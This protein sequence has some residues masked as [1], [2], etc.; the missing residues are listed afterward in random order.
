V[1]M[2]VSRS[3]GVLGPVSKRQLLI[4]FLDLCNHEATSVHVL[5]GRATPGEGLWMT[6]LLVRSAAD[7]VV[8]SWVQVGSCGSWQGRTSRRG[9]R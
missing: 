4:P 5:T 3:L 9:T 7:I 8:R 6:W 2:V 1:W